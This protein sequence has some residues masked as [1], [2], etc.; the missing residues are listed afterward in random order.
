MNPLE[1]SNR[2]LLRSAA[3]R[4][5]ELRVRIG[6]VRFPVSDFWLCVVLIQPG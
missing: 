2:H 3:L 1:V 6:R 4:D 5:D